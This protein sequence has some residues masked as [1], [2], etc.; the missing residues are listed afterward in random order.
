M[1]AHTAEITASRIRSLLASDGWSHWFVPLL[2]RLKDDIKSSLTTN[3][4]EPE[5]AHFRAR[6]HLLTELESKP[7]QHLQQCL[8]ALKANEQ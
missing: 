5:T 6:F 1:A 7:A 2:R 3:L 8:E 4:P